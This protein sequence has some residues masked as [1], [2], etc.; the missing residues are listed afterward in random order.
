MQEIKISYQYILCGIL[1]A[2]AFVL[3]ER[4]V[5]AVVEIENW[6]AY[7]AAAFIL[8]VLLKKIMKSDLQSWQEVTLNILL[9][10]AIVVM[11][12]SK[13]FSNGS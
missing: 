13:F 5:P 11:V 3:I 2:I 7:F 1:L 9:G 6:L 8:F 4:K 12:Q 10:W